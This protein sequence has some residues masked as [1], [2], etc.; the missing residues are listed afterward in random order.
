M[1]W[2]EQPEGAQERR[3]NGAEW[4]LGEDQPLD[5]LHGGAAPPDQGQV[6]L[7]RALEG[8]SQPLW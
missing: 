8:A 6:G 4:L 1:I 2:T 5:M 7:R 3:E